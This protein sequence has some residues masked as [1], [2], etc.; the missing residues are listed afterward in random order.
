M[1]RAMMLALLAQLAAADVSCA[2]RESVG[3]G[4]PFGAVPISTCESVGCV[5]DSCPCAEDE[6]EATAWDS[7]SPQT[8][9]ARAR[10]GETTE[11]IFN[12]KTGEGSLHC[13]K[14]PA[15]CKNVFVKDEAYCA[16]LPEQQPDPNNGKV[17]QTCNDVCGLDKDVVRQ[18]YEDG[19]YAQEY[20]VRA[21]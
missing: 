16:K 18:N 3:W 15:V 13:W 14:Q 6:F 21:H 12:Q 17:C 4:D 8:K 20:E 11:A 9:K 7:M 2:A 5:K 1:M 10:F 19:A